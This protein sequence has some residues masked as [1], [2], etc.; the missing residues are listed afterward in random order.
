[1]NFILKMFKKN[2]ILLVLNYLEKTET[3][4]RW[5]NKVNERVDLPGLNEDEE[6]KLFDEITNKGFEEIKELIK[7]I[8]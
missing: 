3:K 4:E 7:E 1:M 8:K 2:I 6:K 5:V